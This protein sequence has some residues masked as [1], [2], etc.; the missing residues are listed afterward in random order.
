[1]THR[2]RILAAIEHKP[3]DR[4][5]TDF[6]GTDEVV[7]KLMVH[8][9]AKTGSDLWNALDI[10][11][12]ADVMPQY[13]GPA[14]KSEGD[15]RED[16]FGVKQR[17]IQY[18]D[19]KGIYYE[20]CESPLEKFS[21]VDEIK[22]H[23]QWPT[24]DMF[25]F[26]A[27]RDRCREN[28]GYAIAAGYIAPFYIYTRLRGM[29]QTYIDLAADEDLAFYIIGK[30]REF[31][32][33]FHTRLYEAAPGQ[34]DIAQV[35]DDYGGQ[36]GLLI[37]LEMFDR[38]FRDT[39]R[40]SVE[41][42]K[43]YG[44]KV[45]HHDDGAIRDIIPSL[46]DLGIDILNPVQWRLPGMDLHELKSSFGEAICFHGAID[47]QH[48]LPFGTTDEVKDEVRLCIDTLGA[49]ATGFILAPCHNLQPNT[50][51]ENILTMY[52]EAH[53]YGRY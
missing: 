44:I 28:S 46:V 47:N 49:G 21:S 31:L 4:V 38:Y 25:D 3:V 30:I 37:S 32:F 50:S 16:C 5:P 17:P 1:M 12:I 52:S 19:G 48:V 36:N 9:G 8:F 45:F 43:S 39:F 40:D 35:T 22:A 33:D 53:R 27:V 41:L 10:D 34:I 11:K 15:L 14:F 18:G 51:V 13:L 6:W 7:R 24:S 23:Y 2:E 26:D 42:V 29:E 20:I